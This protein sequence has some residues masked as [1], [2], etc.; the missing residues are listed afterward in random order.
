MTR[1]GYADNQNLK[2]HGIQIH[3]GHGL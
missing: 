2:K 3:R 1:H